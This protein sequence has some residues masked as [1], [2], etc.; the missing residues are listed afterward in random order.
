MPPS[1][2][3]KSHNYSE[4]ERPNGAEAVHRDAPPPYHAQECL[5]LL[6]QT[7]GKDDDKVCAVADFVL[8]LLRSQ[9]KHLGCGVFHLRQKPAGEGC[10]P[11]SSGGETNNRSRASN[12]RMMVAASLVTKSLSR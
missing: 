10:T 2:R 3:G 6:Q 9:D 1:E 7:A 4:V 5:C 12:S 11:G 8:L